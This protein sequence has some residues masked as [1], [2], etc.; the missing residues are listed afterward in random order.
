[1]ASA[2]EERLCIAWLVIYGKSTVVSN[3]ENGAEQWKMATFYYYRYWIC[4]F[5]AMKIY[6]SLHHHRPIAMKIQPNVSLAAKD[7]VDVCNN[8]PTKRKPA[9]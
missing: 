1:M 2:K 3:A 5:E 4:L 8:I 9:T 7:A 6:H